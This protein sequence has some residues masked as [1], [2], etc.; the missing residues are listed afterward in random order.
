MINRKILTLLFGIIFSTIYATSAYGQEEAK[1]SCITAKC[2]TNIGKAKFVHGPAAVG[3]CVTCHQLVKDEKHKFLPIQNSEETC[4]KCHDPMQKKG[5]I[6]APVAKGECTKCHDPHQS[7]RQFQLKKSSTSNLCFSCHP[8]NLTTKKFTHGPAAEGEY[9]VIIRTAL[10][11][12][13]CLPAIHLINVTLA[14]PLY[15]HQQQN[16]R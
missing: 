10:M 15:R 1:P 9:N 5:T 6:H 11:Q 4:N 16:L 8:K 3:E 13:I 2:H 12:N 14:M 7:D